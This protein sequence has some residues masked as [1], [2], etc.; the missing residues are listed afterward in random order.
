MLHAMEAIHVTTVMARPPHNSSP[1]FVG[2][3][4]FALRPDY[5]GVSTRMVNRPARV[6][7]S[8]VTSVDAFC[9][10]EL[11]L[12]IILCCSSP[13]LLKTGIRLDRNP[14]LTTL[15]LCV[16]LSLIPQRRGCGRA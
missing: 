13:R 15:V 6:A 4:E 1:F 12:R 11:M 9:N 5:V 7:D 8:S 14:M 3:A 16:L 2:N 10:D